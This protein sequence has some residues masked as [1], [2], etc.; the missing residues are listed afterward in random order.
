MPF[1]NIVAEK[2]NLAAPYSIKALNIATT[3]SHDK[4]IIEFKSGHVGFMIG[5]HAHK[6]L[7]KLE[8]VTCLIA[9][10]ASNPFIMTYPFLFNK[11]CK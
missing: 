1:L 9:S 4:N 2:D 7:A 10:S 5:K 3:E 11:Y 6:K 8:E